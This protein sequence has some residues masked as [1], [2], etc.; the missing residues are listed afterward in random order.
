MALFLSSIS[1][2]PY[3][4]LH[5]STL[6]HQSLKAN[7]GGPKVFM[8][9]CSEAKESSAEP[10]KNINVKLEIGSP[11]VVTEAPKIIKTATSVPCLRVNSGLVKP[12]DVGRYDS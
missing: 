1:T 5:D 2:V 4:K 11:I 12:G 3:T 6:L 7:T 9:K 8:I 10:S